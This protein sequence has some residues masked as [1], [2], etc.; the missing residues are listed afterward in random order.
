[1]I[2]IH[3]V[4][5]LDTNYIW[6]IQPDEHQPQVLVVDPGT[7]APL[8]ALLRQQGLVPI[9]IV[10]T[11]H[12]HDHI[13]GIAP[14]QQAY[15]PIPVYG[16]SSERIPQITQPLVDGQLL[17]LAPNPAPSVIIQA[18]ATPGH[19][20]D[21]LVYFLPGDQREPP[22]LFSGD[23][24]FAGG[25]GRRNEDTAERM[26]AALQTLAALPGNTLLYCA[27]EYTLD[28]LRF[29]IHIEPDNHDLHERLASV[30]A[31]RTQQG[32]TLPSNMALENRTNPFLRC[33]LPQVKARLEELCGE[34][35]MTD[36]EV[37]GAMRALKDHWR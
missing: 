11:H 17:A 1:M 30:Q 6:L 5:A 26:W 36:A 2:R 10:I 4:P 37:F 15:G 33:H 12:H 3:P 13:R 27:H 14:L 32:I 28:N 20:R 21:H 8:Q 23:A 7:D 34:P 22:R 16:P 24:L 9:A 31:L 19:T 18:L 29:A 35:L 25:C